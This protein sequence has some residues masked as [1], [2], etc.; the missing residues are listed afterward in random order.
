MSLRV[1]KDSRLRR[2]EPS[3]KGLAGAAAAA[4]ALLPSFFLAL[5][6]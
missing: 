1:P 2:L 6:A 5:P 3:L 4:L